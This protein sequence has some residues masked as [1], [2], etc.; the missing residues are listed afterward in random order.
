MFCP[1]NESEPVSSVGP[2]LL[3]NIFCIIYCI[4][5]WILDDSTRGKNKCFTEK[6]LKS[7]NSFYTISLN[8]WFSNFLYQPLQ[9]IFGSPSS[10]I[11]SNITFQQ[12]RP[13]Y[14]A[15]ALHSFTRG[16]FIYCCQ[17][18]QHCKYTV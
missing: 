8:Q 4:I 12:R 18:L 1:F 16:S 17:P 15:T 6:F 14:S 13:N 3:P 2:A 7:M 9:K 10:T 11:M 5:S